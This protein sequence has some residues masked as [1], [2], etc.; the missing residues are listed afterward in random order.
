MVL[1]PYPLVPLVPFS[2][3]IEDLQNEKRPANTSWRIVHCKYIRKSP[4][5]VLVNDTTIRKIE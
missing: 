5:A 3:L 2:D 4:S 1:V